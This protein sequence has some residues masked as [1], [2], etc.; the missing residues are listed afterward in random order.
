MTPF[1]PEPTVSKGRTEI[2]S[3][4]QQALKLRSLLG[5]SLKAPC[6]PNT[7]EFYD[8]GVWLLHA[9]CTDLKDS[10]PQESDHKLGGL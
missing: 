4:T 1:C 3:H 8:P 6:G 2:R 9:I 10:N 5:V 7:L